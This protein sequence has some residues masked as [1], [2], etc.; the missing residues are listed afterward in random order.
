MVEYARQWA[1]ARPYRPTTVRTVSSLIENHIA[2]MSIGNRK[3][4]AL[5][6]SEVQARATERSK[7][8]SLLRLRNLLGILKQMYRDA[9][10]DRLV[11]IS[12][13]V[14]TANAS[15]RVS[16]RSAVEGSDCTQDS[17]VTPN[18]PVAEY[19]SPSP[20]GSHR[21]VPTN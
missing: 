10:L 6:P 3:L 19:H 18:D 16:V 9:L 13:V 7:L 15:C 20:G 8:M 4:I 2:G 1:A 17:E 12:P 14:P 21:Q 5:R 11:G